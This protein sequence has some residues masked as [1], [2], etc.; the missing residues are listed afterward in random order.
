MFKNIIHSIFTKGIVALINFFILIITSR[1]FGISTRGEIS[2]FIL[3]ITIIQLI[4]ETY[5]GYS[6]VYFIPKFNLKKIFIIGIIYTLIFTSLSNLIIVFINKQIIGFEWMG[7]I[8][9]LIIIINSFNSVLI[10]GKEKVKLYN[11]LNFL[12]PFL[13][14]LGVLIYIFILNYN[15]ISAFVFPLFFSFAISFIISFV[16]AQKLVFFDLSLTNY[17]FKPIIIN[18]I[19]CQASTLMFI[20]GNR[21]SYYLLPSTSKIG[22][23][24]TASSLIE[25]IL[26]IS[27]GISPILLARVANLGDTKQ[28]SKITLSLSKISLIISTIAVM[29]IF[30]IPETLYLK[31]LGNEFIGIKRLM[32]LYA[33][34]I[35][36]ISFFGIISNY[37]S[38]LG[39]L[40]LILFCNSFG[41]IITL[42]FTPILIKKYDV[43]GA[44]YSVNLAYLAVA[45]AIG[46]AFFLTNNMKLKQLFSFKND[47]KNLKDLITSKN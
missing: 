18:G 19:I 45:I 43:D 10:L 2:I 27:N 32:M 15:S 41:F 22:L 7:Y 24:S 12:Q 4:N 44:A 8:I 20:L 13:L 9:S 14:L 30:I 28:S 11:F 1:Y 29:I 6:L 21:Y 33:P 38:A 16:Y 40:K 25:S 5:T 23:Y 3:N 35:L 42:I 26:I 47:L 37:F 39:K 36:M 34:G 31:I 46:V 17:K